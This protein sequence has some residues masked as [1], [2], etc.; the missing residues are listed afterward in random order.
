MKKILATP[1]TETTEPFDPKGLVGLRSLKP[2]EPAGPPT[3]CTVQNGRSL[4][5]PSPSGQ[6]RI[7]GFDTTTGENVFALITEVF[8]PGQTLS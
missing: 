8:Q 7:V 5:V 6:K 3:E 1:R 4:Q 2:F